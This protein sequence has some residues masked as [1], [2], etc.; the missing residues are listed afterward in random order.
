MNLLKILIYITLFFSFALKAS[1][2]KEAISA[3]QL[4][5]S[6]DLSEKIKSTE[7]SE[8]KLYRQHHACLAILK[9]YGEIG[10][11]ESIYQFKN[12]QLLNGVHIDYLY[13][14]D[15]VDVEQHAEWSS[16]ELMQK[17]KKV[18]VDR[19]VADQAALDDILHYVDDQLLEKNCQ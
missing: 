9:V 1:Y 10:Q 18:M 17:A 16:I 13:Q 2:A 11:N 4:L 6:I 15:P 5:E 12:K 19:S 3:T 7:G 8:L 14:L